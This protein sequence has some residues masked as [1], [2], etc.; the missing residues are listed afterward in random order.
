MNK[1]EIAVEIVNNIGNKA[2]KPVISTLEDGSKGLYIILKVIAEI[3]EEVSAIDISNVLNISIAR[4]TV[5]L[6]KLEEKGLITREKSTSDKRVT[7]VKLTKLGFV[8]LEEKKQSLLE[9]INQTLDKLTLEECVQLL[10]IY[11]KISK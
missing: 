1:Q 11:Q 10:N 9:L 2:F 5:A 6:K 8:K 7:I 4:V 3:N